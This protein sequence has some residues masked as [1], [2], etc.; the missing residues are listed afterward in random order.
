MASVSEQSSALVS[1]LES[2]PFS[3]WHRTF[4]LVA[5]FGTLF[6]AADF[7]LFGG[8]LPLIRQE[9]GLTFQQAGFL[10]TIGLV[11]AFLG[12]LFW[13][14][15]SDY[16][17]RRTA[18]SATVGIF[19]VFTGLVAAS[20]SVAS[21]AVFRF[22]SNFGLGGE[23]P[24][25]STLTVE[26][27]PGR[28]RGSAT[29]SMMTAFPIGLVVAAG[30]S[31]L[32]IPH[33]GWRG[34]FV[35]GILPAFLLFFVA[36]HMPESV[37]YLLSRGRIEEATRT[38]E[39]IERRAGVQPAPRAAADIKPDVAT[40]PGIT[41]LQLFA[42]GRA[43]RTILLWIVSFCFLWSSNG[44]LF[45]LP[46][47]LTQRGL[48]LSDAILLQLV[49]AGAAIFGY[50]ACSFW[51]DRYGRRP[52]LFLYY[53]IGAGFHLWFAMASGAWMFA[54]IASVGWV[55]PGVYGPTTVYAGELYPTQMRATAVGWVF[56]IGRIGSFL[57]PTIVGLMLQFGLGA[58]VLHTF[59]LTYL[60]AAFALIAV[61]IETKGKAL[62]QISAEE[63][64]EAPHLAPA[65]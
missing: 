14:T 50:S 46:T 4:F 56:G 43:P 27:M 44:I 9:Y 47:I 39:D 8:A 33:F 19:A 45:M 17:G 22:L 30:L 18:F 65:Q 20:W 53:L 28:I 63:G 26:F 3:R 11:G 42:A 5:F 25:A 54:A 51:I 10:A 62:E 35:V 21:L 24:V 57:A 15:I 1:R 58:Y 23:V 55:N 12:A 37:R 16:V 49:Q 2:L 34:L 6:D 13:G 29:G 59:A 32:I 48:P 52:V 36:R 64:E 40:P 41:V 31:L 7:A 60:I 61:G 38:V